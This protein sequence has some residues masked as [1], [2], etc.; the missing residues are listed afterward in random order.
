[1]TFN[2]NSLRE[3]G[4]LVQ[5]FGVKIL[6]YGPPGTSKTPQ[7]NTLPNPILLCIEP[8][9][10][11][12]VGSKV[13]T[14]LCDT[15]AKIDDFMKWLK[16]S[17][18]AKRFD[19]VAVDSVS[20]MAERYLEKAEA[21][22]AHGMAAYGDMAEMTFAHLSDLFYL[23]NKH[24]YLI[25]KEDIVQVGN[26]QKRRPYFPGKELNT[27]V[28]HLY[29]AVWRIGVEQIPGYGAN[30]CIRTRESYECIAR[31]RSGKLAELEPPNV[32]N[33]IAKIMSN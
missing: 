31:D 12:M 11:S 17:N 14:A 8:G 16:G 6:F 7:V 25:A 30:L 19:T 2:I 4:Q 3:A 20:Q 28:P 21:E 13:P 15:P 10:R 22:N 24:I 32:G 9:L 26:T 29:D 33:L 23:Q 1:M 27:K 5:H 18:E